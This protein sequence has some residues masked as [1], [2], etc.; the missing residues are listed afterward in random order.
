MQRAMACASEGEH[1]ASLCHH[2]E[3]PLN[4]SQVPVQDLDSGPWARLDDQAG[5]GAFLKLV[6]LLNQQRP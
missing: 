5:L 1:V 2:E 4:Q 3:K 6:Q